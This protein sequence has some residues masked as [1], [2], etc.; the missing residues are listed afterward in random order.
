VE[1]LDRYIGQQASQDVKKHFASVFVMVHEE[2]EGD[3]L[4]FYSLS[5]ASV[6]LGS[7]PEAQ[8][9]AMPRYPN[10]PAARLGRL[11]V[12]S[13]SQGQGLGGLLL[14]DALLRA[15]RS[16]LAWAAFVVDAKDE[17]AVFFYKKFG[18]LAF[19]DEPRRLFLPRASVD[20]LAR[21]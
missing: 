10:V 21:G 3:I 19:Q 14:V 16:D 13:S 7:L 4:G 6:P 15:A 5:M 12:S 20:V 9:A 17:R 18:F 1:A 8:R 2:R 11:A